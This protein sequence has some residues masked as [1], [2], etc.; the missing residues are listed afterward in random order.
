MFLAVRYDRSLLPLS[1][2]RT[3]YS[4]RRTTSAERRARCNVVRS[5]VKILAL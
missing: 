5:M 4:L 2:W 1:F 3:V